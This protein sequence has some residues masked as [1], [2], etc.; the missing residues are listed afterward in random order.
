MNN[1]IVLFQY[2]TKSHQ[3]YIQISSTFQLYPKCQHK[4]I[5]N[6]KN[7]FK[8]EKFFILNEK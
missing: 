2:V 8:I 7:F 3:L 5:K 4:K 6:K 1:T